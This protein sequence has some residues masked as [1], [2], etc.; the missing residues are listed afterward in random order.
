[1]AFFKIRMLSADPVEIPEVMKFR[2]GK[3]AVRRDKAQ[4]GKEACGRFIYVSRV[5]DASERL[6]KRKGVVKGNGSGVDQ[7]VFYRACHL[8]FLIHDLLLPE[9]VLPVRNGKETLI[10]IGVKCQ[11]AF[12]CGK[13]T[14]HMDFLRSGQ[15]HTRNYSDAVVFSVIEGSGTVPAAVVVRQSNDI[16][17]LDRSHPD[18]ICRSHVIIPAWGK[19]GMNVQVIKKRDHSMPAL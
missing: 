8:V 5:G 18:Q 12:Q 13:Q 6:H 11:R 17:S 14:D 10:Y 7:Q 4:I 1:M 3:S 19:A 15:F 2:T 9:D 16:Q